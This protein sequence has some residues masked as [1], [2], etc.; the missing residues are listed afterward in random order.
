[1]ENEEQSDDDVMMDHVALEAMHAI[2]RKDKES[3]RNSF[4]VLVG[5][6]LMQMDAGSDE[7]E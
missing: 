5:H 2:D 1:M 3:F 7:G 6:T 4:H